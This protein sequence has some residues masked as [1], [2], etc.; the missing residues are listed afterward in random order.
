MEML[1][2]R[3]Q[4]QLDETLELSLE[5]MPLALSLERRLLH[6]H[7]EYGHQYLNPE[8]MQD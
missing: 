6:L 3:V 2:Q 1:Q 5:Q 4:Q 7:D 8:R